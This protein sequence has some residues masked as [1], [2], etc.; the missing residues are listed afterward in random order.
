MHN[1]VKG[2]R[3]N[4]KWYI[5]SSDVFTPMVHVWNYLMDNNY[6]TLPTI[7]Q[8]PGVNLANNAQVKSF[9]LQYEK[10]E[11]TKFPTII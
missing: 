11:M 3:A 7:S 5:Q 10:F 9:L 4:Q 8:L 1:D 2:L 6:F